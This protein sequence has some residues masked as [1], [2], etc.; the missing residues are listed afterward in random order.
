MRWPCFEMAEDAS[1][2]AVQPGFRPG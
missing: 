2:E 1:L